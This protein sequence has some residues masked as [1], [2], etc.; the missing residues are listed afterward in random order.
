M[1]D[2]RGGVKLPPVKLR[3][4]DAIKLGGDVGL[5]SREVIQIAYEG[6]TKPY[7]ETIKSHV[8]QMNEMLDGTGLRIVSEYHDKH[9]RYWVLHTNQRTENGK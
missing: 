1:H 2:L 8:C 6:K 5:T 9:E 3:I 7:V 4:F